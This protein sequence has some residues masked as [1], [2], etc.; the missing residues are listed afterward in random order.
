MTGGDWDG[1]GGTSLLPQL[2][3]RNEQVCSAAQSRGC[4]AMLG[5]SMLETAC[6]LKL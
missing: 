4:K 2:G 3:V 1:E 6:D 5:G